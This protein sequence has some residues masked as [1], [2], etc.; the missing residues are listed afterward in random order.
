MS[1]DVHDAVSLELARRVASG[2]R[3]HPDWL[4][5]ARANLERWTRLNNGATSLLR[6][7]GEWVALLSRPVGEVCRALVADTEEG[8]RLRQN[9]PFAGVLSPAEVWQIKSQ[10]RRH[11]TRAA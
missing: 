6:C 2:L 5:R 10:F 3:E 4:D 8:R 9:S 11:A 1:H 7:Y